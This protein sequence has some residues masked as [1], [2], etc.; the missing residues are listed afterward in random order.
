M[1]TRGDLRTRL[2]LFK[3]ESCHMTD[4]AYGRQGTYVPVLQDPERALPNVYGLTTSWRLSVLLRLC[5]VTF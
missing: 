1:G 3:Y 2:V 4:R 5:H